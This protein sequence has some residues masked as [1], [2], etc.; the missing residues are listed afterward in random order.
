MMSSDPD[1]VPVKPL[2]VQFICSI[3][4]KEEVVV[5]EFQTHQVRNFFKFFPCVG[6][7]MWA[8]QSGLLIDPSHQVTVRVSCDGATL[9]ENVFAPSVM[10]RIGVRGKTIAS[11]DE[12]VSVILRKCKTT[13]QLIVGHVTLKCMPAIEPL[14]AIAEREFAIAAHTRDVEHADRVLPAMRASRDMLREQLE[15]QEKTFSTTVRLSSK[16]AS[17]WKLSRNSDMPQPKPRRQHPPRIQLQLQLDKNHHNKFCSLHALQK[18]IVLDTKI[19]FFQNFFKLFRCRLI[20]TPTHSPTQPP[21]H[22][23]NV[24]LG[25]RHR[26]L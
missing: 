3:A 19:T 17:T 2:F 6:T 11:S 13:S 10:K 9:Y 7:N 18:K 8:Q 16:S 22:T 12:F 26:S 5:Q 23:D 21:P 14:V 20:R 15:R 24:E 1:A 4:G 25:S